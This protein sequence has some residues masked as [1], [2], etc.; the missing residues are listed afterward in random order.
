MIVFFGFLFFCKDGEDEEDDEGESPECSTIWS[1]VLLGFVSSSKLSEPLPELLVL[2]SSF[3]F[4]LSVSSSSSSSWLDSTYKKEKG[5]LK[6]L[7]TTAI[8]ELV[9]FSEA[10]G[11]GWIL[12]SVVIRLSGANRQ[13][14]KK[15]VLEHQE[16]NG[17]SLVWNRPHFR[18]RENQD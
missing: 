18:D 4:I 10:F 11:M 6:V 15:G 8:L 12:R 14:L 17:L 13:K 1:M 3:L 7:E 5:S 9:R 16:Q 2:V